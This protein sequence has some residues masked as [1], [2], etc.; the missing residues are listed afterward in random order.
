MARAA[1]VTALPHVLVWEHTCSCGSVWRAMAIEILSRPAGGCCSGQQSACTTSSRSGDGCTGGAR[2][3]GGRGRE[4][5]AC[6][7]S[8]EGARWSDQQGVA[9]RGHQGGHVLGARLVVG[10]QAH[11]VSGQQRRPPLPAPALP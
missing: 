7:G 3:V 4:E 1:A 9:V 2:E 8:P 6:S 11:R 10:P 5:P